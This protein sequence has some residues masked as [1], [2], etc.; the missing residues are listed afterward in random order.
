MTIIVFFIIIFINIFLLK[1]SI[2]SWKNNFRSLEIV[3]RSS[4]MF[5]PGLVVHSH[6]C[7]VSVLPDLA[8]ISK[9]IFLARR[10]NWT[11]KYHVHMAKLLTQNAKIT[12]NQPF[13][14]IFLPLLNLSENW[15]LITCKQ[16][17]AEYM[18]N[19]GSYSASQIIDVTKNC[20][21]SAL[22][23][24]F[25]P[26]LNLSENWSFVTCITNSGRIHAKLF[27]LS[28]PQKN[29][30]VDADPNDAEIQLQ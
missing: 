1:N 10:H 20:H 13:W 30:D 6:T 24:F 19:F 15:S 29:V 5:Y 8:H 26:L 17:W 18:K 22:L 27:K 7:V 25:Q 2:G 28:C 4:F 14:F 9:V 11:W 21:K 16:I 12:I 3:S 23:I